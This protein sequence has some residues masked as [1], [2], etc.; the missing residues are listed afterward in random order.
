ML[1]LTVDKIFPRKRNDFIGT[2]TSMHKVIGYLD[3]ENMW[4]YLYQIGIVRIQADYKVATSS[5]YKT[6][7]VNN[8]EPKEGM[9]S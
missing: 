7:Q 8:E 3:S 5:I 9:I 2:D 1:K 4:E 6:S